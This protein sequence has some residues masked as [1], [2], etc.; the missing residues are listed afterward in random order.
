M[1]RVAQRHRRAVSQLLLT[2]VQCAAEDL[3]GLVDVAGLRQ[4]RAGVGRQRQRQRVVQADHA[5]VR[6]GGL[7]VGVRRGDDL[8]RVEIQ[9]RQLGHGVQHVLVVVAE[10]L[11]AAHHE[12]LAQLGGILELPAVLEDIQEALGAIEGARVVGAERLDAALQH[13]REEVRG[14]AGIAHAPDQRGQVVQRVQRVRVRAAELPPAA[15]ARLPVE[16]QGGGVIA[17]VVVTHRKIVGGAQCVQVVFAQDNRKGVQAPAQER[18]NLLAR[19]A[20]LLNLQ[21]QLARRP[22]HLQGVVLLL[23]HGTE[24]LEQR[25]HV[26]LRVRVRRR[27]LRR[28]DEVGDDLGVGLVLGLLGRER[29]VVATTAVRVP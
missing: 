19:S 18:A 15:F 4:Q 27:G 12:R 25:A 10:A 16:Q 29:R 11:A 23:V 28:A 17:Q 24:F 9:V 21:R 13:L 20:R 5:G 8:R 22:R 7:A 3:D 14:L 2:F 26:S 1:I 6:G